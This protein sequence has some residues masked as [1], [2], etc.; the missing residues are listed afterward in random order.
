MASIMFNPLFGAFFDSPCTFNKH[1]FFIYVSVNFPY[2]VRMNQK[3]MLPLDRKKETM[4]EGHN[5]VLCTPIKSKETAIVLNPF[6]TLQLF[7]SFY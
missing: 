1:F 4:Q 7:Q 2:V 3:V 6:F 5:G